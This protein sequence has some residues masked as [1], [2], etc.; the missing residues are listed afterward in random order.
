MINHMIKMYN[1]NEQLSIRIPKFDLY[2]VEAKIKTLK[3]KLAYLET[4][5]CRDFT[6]E[7]ARRELIKET[8]ASF[9]AALKERDELAQQR[10]Y[11]YD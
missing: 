6:P 9:R 3:D 5:T 11:L 2:I 4:V 8:T 7:P 1:P 10:D